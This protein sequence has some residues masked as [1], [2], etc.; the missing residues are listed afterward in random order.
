MTWGESSY[1]HCTLRTSHSAGPGMFRGSLK[2]YILQWHFIDDGFG[3]SQLTVV[4]FM[5]VSDLTFD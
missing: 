2:T 5:D 1:P 4:V 3:L